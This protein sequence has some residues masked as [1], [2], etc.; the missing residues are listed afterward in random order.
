MGRY[1]IVQA[2]TDTN[3]AISYTVVTKRQ[4]STFFIYIYL[5]FL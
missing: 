4:S 2:T 1:V 3:F 5:L